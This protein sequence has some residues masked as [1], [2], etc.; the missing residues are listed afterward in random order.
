MQGCWVLLLNLPALEMLQVNLRY[1]TSKLLMFATIKYCK[2]LQ[3]LVFVRRCSLEK[4][5]LQ[6]DDLIHNFSTF[7][8]NPFCL[9]T[10]CSSGS[11]QLV[12]LCGSSL[13]FAASAQGKLK[14][15]CATE[16]PDLAPPGGTKEDENGLV[17]S[18]TLCWRAPM[19]Q[20][21]QD[22]STEPSQ[23]AAT[24]ILRW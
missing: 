24:R 5:L 22:K 11:K 3:C 1:F 14:S 23:G 8:C 17:W 10:P 9:L 18:F 16:Q 19:A 7:P 13:S 20:H 15:S 4:T 21:N 2:S 12:W 6:Q